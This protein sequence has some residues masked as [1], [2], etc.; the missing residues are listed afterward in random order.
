MAGENSRNA[1]ATKTTTAASKVRNAD[2]CVENE[3]LPFPNGIWP[4]LRLPLLTT[5]AVSELSFEIK[6][7][8]RA[9]SKTRARR[10]I[11]KSNG[12]LRPST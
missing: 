7:M 11:S 8:E 1:D 12:F 4:Q 3:V 2:D 10:V 9:S 6:C 5:S